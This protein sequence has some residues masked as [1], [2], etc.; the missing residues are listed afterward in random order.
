MCHSGNASVMVRE[1]E[2][3]TLVIILVNVEA[4]CLLGGRRISKVK[5][6]L[7]GTSEGFHPDIGIFKLD[8]IGNNSYT[9]H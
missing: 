8:G 6:P 1:S 5:D 7:W 9:L 2:H 4:K 3:S